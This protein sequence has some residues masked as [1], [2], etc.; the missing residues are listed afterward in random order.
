MERRVIVGAPDRFPTVELATTR[1]PDP[2]PAAAPEPPADK[3]GR[4]HIRCT[5]GKLSL[6]ARGPK[7]TAVPRAAQLSGFREIGPERWACR[8]CYRKAVR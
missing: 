8:K 7:A 3:W 6:V 1:T 4:W 5:C 2:A